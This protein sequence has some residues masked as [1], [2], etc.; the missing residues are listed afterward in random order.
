MNI[1]KFESLKFLTCNS[2][3]WPRWFNRQNIFLV[4]VSAIIFCLI[5][6]HLVKDGMLIYAMEPH[7][8]REFDPDLESQI[9]GFS[10]TAI[11]VSITAGIFGVISFL[12][13]FWLVKLI[14]FIFSKFKR[15]N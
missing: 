9:R 15:I 2:L 4:L 5:F 12:I 13:L 6:D 14:I 3:N 7:I 1:Q 11:F 8:D 10:Y